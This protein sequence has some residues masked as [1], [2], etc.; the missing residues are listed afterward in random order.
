[1]RRAKPRDERGSTL[2][3][4]LIMLTVVG[5]LVAAGLGHASTSMRASNND[6]V[7]NR[8]SLYAA[9]SAVQAAIQY[10]RANPQVGSDLLGATCTPNAFRYDD[11]SV[12]AVLVDICPQADSFTYAGG[13]RAVLMTL[14]PSGQGIVQTKNNTVAVNGNVWSNSFIDVRGLDVGSGQ[15]WA[16]NDAGGGGN[17]ASGSVTASAGKDCNTRNTYGFTNLASAMSAG[18][19]TMVV[20]TSTRFPASGPYVVVVDDERML[21]TGGQGATTWNV[22]RG[23]LGTTAAAHGNGAKVSFLPKPGID[24]G[25]PVLGRAAEWTPAGA[26]GVVRNTPYTC[27]LQPGTYTHG[28]DLTARWSGCATITLA[29]GAYYL[30]F[31]PDGSG[32]SANDDTWTINGRLQGPSCASD[33]DAGAQLVLANASRISNA[34]TIDLPCGMRA[35]PTAPRIAVTSL[36]TAIAGGAST[37]TTLRPAV[38]PAQGADNLF[39]PATL[40][41]VVPTAAP[42]YPQDNTNASASVS[43]NNK[44]AQL[45]I[46]LAG[47]AGQS[48]P[49]NAVI[50]NVIVKVGHD[51]TTDTQFPAGAS[52]LTWG[53]CTVNLAPVK[54]SPSGT[55]T[56]FQSNVT[57]TV[58]ACTNFDPSQP[59]TVRWSVKTTSG[60][61]STIDVDGAQLDVTWHAPG[62]PAQQGCVYHNTTGSCPA[63]GSAS[64]N[65]H[66]SFL[67][68]DV[69]YLPHS[70]LQTTCKNSCSFN[71]GQA[72]IAWSVSLDANPAAVGEPVIGGDVNTDGEGDVLFNAHIG[73]DQWIA[74]RVKYPSGRPVTVSS[75]VVKR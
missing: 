15:V 41:N 20:G 26:P 45:D 19:S 17:C 48:I 5:L 58:T 39:A 12:G 37:V 44:T 72:L 64:A 67:V 16:W 13:V 55:P 6:I 42:G 27:V 53:S 43:K 49:A 40:G 18:S 46:G 29:P 51:E 62:I 8:A 59:A 7:P 33:T 73:A 54:S 69:V 4:A 2:V 60:A 10:V 35:T 56:L 32:R 57:A 24:P 14:A 36:N 70:Q 38:A 30:D 50:D 1:M 71:I 22:T 63:I 25:D 75:W 9:D 11:P 61:A 28:D 68:D 21:V 3:M 74:S 31:P 52:T 47:T 65:G 34:E 23:Y 66:D